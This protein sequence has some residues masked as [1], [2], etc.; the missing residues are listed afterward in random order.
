MALSFTSGT[1]KCTCQRFRL[2]KPSGSS[3]VI[4]RSS[5]SKAK[6]DVC[7]LTHTMK[8]GETV[9][10]IATGYGLSLDDMQ[11]MNP[12]TDLDR[13]YAGSFHIPLSYHAALSCHMVEE[14]ANFHACYNAV[15]CVCHRPND[16][17]VAF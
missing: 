12:D 7:P 8:Y 4:R 2:S 10:Q 15:S 11:N 9:W 13:V 6:H 16:S 3:L 1:S 5:A 14:N 17:V